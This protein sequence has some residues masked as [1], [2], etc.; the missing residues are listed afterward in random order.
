[1]LCSCHTFSEKGKNTVYNVIWMASTA[2]T[3]FARSFSLSLSAVLK[4]LITVRVTPYLYT[5]VQCTP[6]HRH[7][8]NFV[9]F[10]EVKNWLLPTFRVW[11]PS[12]TLIRNC[13]KKTHFTWMAMYCTSDCTAP[14]I[15]RSASTFLYKWRYNQFG[16]SEVKVEVVSWTLFY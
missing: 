5:L 14:P 1:M 16:D 13:Q 15:V 8:A 7:F 11:T 12:R 2:S 10:F 6:I 4:C 3:L 9:S